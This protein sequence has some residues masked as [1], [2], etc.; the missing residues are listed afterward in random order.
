MTDDTI[1]QFLQSD[2]FYNGGTNSPGSEV[3]FP[4]GGGPVITYGCTDPTAY[5]YNPS[6]MEDNGTCQY[7]TISPPP[8]T[9]P[10]LPPVNVLG[11]TDR[12]AVNYNATATLDDGSCFWNSFILGCTDPTASNYN[13]SANKDDGSCITVVQLPPIIT[14]TIGCGDISALNYD[15]SANIFDNSLCR[16]ESTPHRVGCTNPT[17]KNYDP[18]AIADDGSCE[19]YPPPPPPGG[20]VSGCTRPGNQNYNPSAT[21][22]DGSCIPHVLGCTFPNASNYNSR[23]T[24]DDGSC[25]FEYPIYGCT[26][27]N[28]INYNRLATNDDGSCR[29]QAPLT[30]GC[31]NPSA[32]N[33]DPNA[34]YHDGSMC[35]YDKIDLPPQEPPLFASLDLNASVNIVDG[36]SPIKVEF[37]VVDPAPA[38]NISIE[39]EPVELNIS[40]VILGLINAYV[41]DAY[42]T[43]IDPDRFYKLLL[44]YGEDR[45]NVIANYRLNPIDSTQLQLKLTKPVPEEVFTNSSVFLGREIAKT[46]IDDIRITFSPAKDKTPYLRPLNNKVQVPGN[47]KQTVQANLE[48]LQL[49]TGSVGAL[50]DIAT[51]EDSIFRKW[52]SYDWDSTELNQSFTDYNNFVFYGSAELRLA[53]F[54]EKLRKIELA[55]LN[56]L[57]SAAYLTTSSTATGSFSTLAGPITFA[58]DYSEV[59][60]VSGSLANISLLSTASARYAVEIEN[61]IRTFDPYERYLFYGDNAIPYSASADY[62]EGEIEYNPSAAWPKNSVGQLLSISTP[63]ASAWYTTQSQI[64]NRFDEQNQNSLVY[65]IPSHISYDVESESFVTF[66]LA[67]GH[68]F[69]N[70]KPY[71]DQMPTNIYDRNFNPEEGMSID[72]VWEVAENF[73]IKLPNPYSVYS[74]QQYVL[75]TTNQETVRVTSAETWKRFLNS[76]IYLLK[77][78]GSKTAIQSFLRILGIH[79]Q[80]ISVKESELNTTSSFFITEEFSNA[81]EF[82]G[83]TNS[84]IRVPLSSSLRDIKTVQFR[85]AT[86]IAQDVTVANMDDNV[87]INIATFPTDPRLGRIEIVSGSTLVLSSSY[88]KMF[89]NNFMDVMIRRYPSYVDLVVAENDGEDLIYSSSN[90]AI[91]PQLVSTISSSLDL[92]IGGS[93][94]IK[95]AIHF[96][97]VVDEVRAWGELID[98]DSFVAQT[99]DPGSYTGN[100]YTSS[101]QNLFVQLSFNREFNLSTRFIANETPYF[102]LNGVSDPFDSIARTNIELIEVEGFVSNSAY[103]RL[104]RKVRINT[105]TIGGS[106]YTT[107]KI[108][109]AE[110]PVFKPVDLDSD[111]VPTLKRNTSIVKLNE[112]DFKKGTNLVSLTISPTD[113]QNQ[114]IARAFGGFNI[115]NLI[116]DPA[117]LAAPEYK[118]LKELQNIYS[119]HFYS[120]VD[121]NRLIRI[122][123]TVLDGMSEFVDFLVPIKAKV[124]SGIL[125]EPNILERVKILEYRQISVDGTETRRSLEAANTASLYP[126]TDYIYS[127]EKTINVE[128]TSFVPIAGMNE[129]TSYDDYLLRIPVEV[130]PRDIPTNPSSSAEDSYKT[131]ESLIELDDTAFISSPV[132]F[133]ELFV[134]GVVLNTVDN[135]LNITTQYNSPSN[136]TEKDGYLLESLFTDGG[137]I[138]ENDIITFVSKSKNEDSISENAFIT[139]QSGSTILLHSNVFLGGKDSYGNYNAIGLR[140]ELESVPNYTATFESDIYNIQKFGVAFDNNRVRFVTDG[141]GE[142]YPFAMGISLANDANGNPVD[143]NNIKYLYDIGPSTDFFD[144]GVTTYFY[145]EDGLY[146]FPE[147]IYNPIGKNTLNFLSGTY[148]DT[149]ILS[150]AFAEW[151]YGN[152][153]FEND[154]VVQNISSINDIANPQNSTLK[155]I[156]IDLIEQLQVV[157]SLR[158]LLL[159]AETESVR[160]ATLDEL[161]TEQ[162][163]LDKLTEKYNKV[164]DNLRTAAAGN[165]YFYKF[166]RKTPAAGFNSYIPPAI[167]RENWELILYLPTLRQTPK[168]VILDTDQ[169]DIFSKVLSDIT[170]VN[171]TVTGDI[172][173]R[174]EFILRNELNIAPNQTIT[175]VLNLAKI[176]ELLALKFDNSTNYRI[177][178]YRTATQRTADIDSGRPFGAEPTGDHGVLFDAQVNNNIYNVLNPTVRLANGDGNEQTAIYYRITNLESVSKVFRLRLYLYVYEG[179]KKVPLGYLPRHYKFSRDNSTATKRRNYIGCL[180]TQDTT[181]DGLSPIEVTLS[182]GTD[183]TVSSVNPNES[184]ILG[185]GGTLNVT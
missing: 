139:Y 93:G 29:F 87:A 160:L 174:N 157:S 185:G 1:N 165:K 167:D 38:G 133:A 149:R 176:A 34:F 18:L 75:P 132:D 47:Y 107:T 8:P 134:S 169:L 68:Y 14:K 110:P 177:T 53:A 65:L 112:K 37:S 99:Y 129:E 79:P 104:S 147:R 82:D 83:A 164:R 40:S 12:N 103:T 113:F 78:R 148:T 123:E 64:A 184:I 146:R 125:I 180:Q 5:N 105:P 71:I 153:Y 89:N 109:I 3:V 143:R 76:L 128:D 98:D 58:T 21:V 119:K 70:I 175:G 55:Q 41:R 31:K 124:Q 43:F 26:N 62:V 36:S 54:R 111:G 86:D 27:E 60:V 32:K 155:N 94:S 17:A 131:Y 13:A 84:Y 183:I 28:A 145:K 4:P 141:S 48:L 163:V 45:Q 166:K 85:F 122:F 61:I 20:G 90:I 162:T 91:N 10:P 46:F 170:V 136:L 15:P 24:L 39:V 74:I 182:S 57:Q 171:P 156:K 101:I 16:Y 81:L 151:E 22:D 50:G 33:Y 130:G 152:T 114:N 138:K 77:T 97:G 102:N 30:T 144:L 2:E 51:F 96:D 173:G 9:P 118:K 172:F 168:R 135:T 63:S 35:Q 116:G 42:D 121:A 19:F 69:D 142:V 52:Y 108:K 72:L 158:S 137:I 88:H 11:C 120:K 161:R 115:N 92:Y 181:T 59:T 117:E 7:I 154:V 25:M 126:P 178:F 23:A 140:T 150:G 67:V 80:L 44:N 127:L 49:T 66:I 159:E 100:T 106:A 56:S 73:G 179:E 95:S 6:A